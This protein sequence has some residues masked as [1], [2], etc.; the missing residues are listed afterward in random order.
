[1][2]VI[3]PFPNDAK[4]VWLDAKVII[5]DFAMSLLI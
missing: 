3:I 1:M 2:I 4:L 5:N